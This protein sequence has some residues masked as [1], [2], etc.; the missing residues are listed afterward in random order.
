MIVQYQYIKW[1]PPHLTEA[2]ELEFGRQIALVGREHFIREFRKSIGESAKNAHQNRHTNLAT[3]E[4]NVSQS[5]FRKIIKALD[6]G[7]QWAGVVFIFGIVIAGF[8][9]MTGSDWSR[10]FA[11]MV[12][13]MIVVL[14]IYFV[15]VYLAARKFERWIDHLVSK[16]AAHVARDGK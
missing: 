14:G 8:V 2:E 10:I 12:P 5:P 11:R 1:N 13:L 4:E 15:S 9:L 16:Y 3:V 7:L 6:N